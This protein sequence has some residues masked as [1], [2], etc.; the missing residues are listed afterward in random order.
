MEGQILQ[1]FQEVRYGGAR[2]S[3]F[4]CCIM[5]CEEMRSWKSGWLKQLQLLSP[6]HFQMFWRKETMQHIFAQHLRPFLCLKL[7]IALELVHNW[8]HK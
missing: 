2:G 7:E 6:I 8:Q 3:E 5:H 1:I 4:N